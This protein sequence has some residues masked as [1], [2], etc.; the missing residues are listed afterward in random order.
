MSFQ[1]RYVT[2]A[3]S[4]SVFSVPLATIAACAA[5]GGQPRDGRRRLEAEL[6]DALETGGLAG[7]GGVVDQVFGH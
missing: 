2:G 5:P 1:I 3:P 6:A 4:G 7:V